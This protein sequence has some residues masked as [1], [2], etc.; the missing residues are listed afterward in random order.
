MRD[1]RGRIFKLEIIEEGKEVTRI[2]DKIKEVNKTED[3]IKIKGGIIREEGVNLEK[4]TG[5]DPNVPI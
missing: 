1:L 2:E 5:L 3:K 4:V